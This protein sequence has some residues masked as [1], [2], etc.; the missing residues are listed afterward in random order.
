MGCGGNP[1]LFSLSKKPDFG[2]KLFSNQYWLSNPVA[3][4]LAR[5]FSPQPSLGDLE[6]ANLNLGLSLHPQRLILCWLI[7]F[8]CSRGDGQS[9]EDPSL[10]RSGNIPHGEFGDLRV[11]RWISSCSVTKDGLKQ[12]VKE[13]FAFPN[14][15]L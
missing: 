3:L 6:S 1:P 13:H 8:C 4:V 14:L 11:V 7:Q 9:S 12:L 2:D 10:P 15:V 5:C